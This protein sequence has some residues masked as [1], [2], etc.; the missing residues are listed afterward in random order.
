MAGRCWMLVFRVWCAEM[1][2]SHYRQPTLVHRYPIFNVSICQECVAWFSSS[3]RT[4]ICAR[5]SIRFYIPHSLHSNT[6][7]IT[8]NLIFISIIYRSFSF[9]RNH[10]KYVYAHYPRT[11]LTA[12]PFSWPHFLDMANAADVFGHIMWCIRLNQFRCEYLSNFF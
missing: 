3:A 8:V 9:E 10:R 1:W 11:Q 2:R 7:E 5:C 6:R 4:H 12:A